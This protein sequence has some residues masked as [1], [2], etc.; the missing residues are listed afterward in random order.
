MTSETIILPK[1][2][3]VAGNPTDWKPAKDGNGNLKVSKKTGEQ[4]MSN[5]IYLAIPKQD[6]INHVWQKMVAVAST[7]YRNAPNVHPDQYMNDGF[8]WKIID[9]DSSFPP[10]KKPNSTPYNQREGH[11]GHYIIKISTSAFLPDTVVFQNGAY[12]KLE[13]GQIKTGDY[14]VAAVM[15]S[16][17]NDANGAGLYWN[18]AKY[19]LVELGNYIEGGSDGD[20]NPV[21]IFGDAQTR[22]HTGFQGTL[23]PAGGQ[24]PMAP[25]PTMPQQPMAPAPMMPQQPIPPAHDFVQNAM[26]NGVQTAVQQPQSTYPMGATTVTPATGFPSDLPQR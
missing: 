23:P 16:V 3:I 17:R 14:I 18:P 10:K 13:P 2:R 12:H 1:G 25:A 20:D 5:W 4:L 22:S 26:G 7:V 19:E 15:L 11:A 8:A 6:F 24:Q 21:T 9:G